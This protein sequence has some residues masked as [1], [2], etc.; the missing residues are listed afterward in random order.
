LIE[1]LRRYSLRTDG[2]FVLRSGAVSSWY[3]DARQTSYS[4]DGGL[5]VGEAVLAALDPNA[6]A[7]GG[8]TMGA[9]PVAVATAVVAAGKGRPLRSFSV[10]KEVKVHGIASDTGMGRLVGPVRPGDRV[11][12]IDDTVTTGG[13]LLEA[14]GVLG[15]AGV[16]VIQAVVLVDRSNGLV[17]ERTRRLG[18]PFVALLTPDDLGVADPDVDERDVDGQK[19]GDRQQVDGQGVE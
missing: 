9:D 19:V 13:A 18:I 14:A 3:L 4:G 10:R 5:L 6:Q 16:D 17:A 12:V 11:T 8:M 7:L 15:A 1:H 2:P